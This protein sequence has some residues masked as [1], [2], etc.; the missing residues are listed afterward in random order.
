MPPGAEHDHLGA[1]RAAL[2]ALRGPLARVRAKQVTASSVRGAAKAIVTTYFG[3]GRPYFASAGLD[4]ESL[5][6][7]DKW[8]QDLLVLVQKAALRTRYQYTIKAIE[9]ELNGIELALLANPGGSD[10]TRPK[11]L[12][13]KEQLVVTT[14]LKMVPSAGASYEQACI[15]LRD[16]SRKS[17]RGAAAE[18][19]EALRETL[20]HLAPDSEVMGQ[21]GFKCEQGQSKPTMKQKVRFVLSS[22]GKSRSQSEVPENAVAVVDDH[23]G[24]L[25]R[26]VYTRSSL[27]THVGTT[28]QEVQH[29]KA[30]VDVVLSELLE[31]A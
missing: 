29:V 2:G 1:L 13:G 23:V 25:A 3:T 28:R 8:M 30:Y 22:R 4:T 9:Q 10:E 20:D 18:L 15:D 17:Y 26:S 24:A 6:N 21:A 7:L 19:R 31:I 14:L 12:D 16:Q 5:G 11:G 27:S